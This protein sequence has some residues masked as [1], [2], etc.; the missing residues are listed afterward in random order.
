MPALLIGTEAACADRALTP[1]A[2]APAKLAISAVRDM[3]TS[4]RV[5]LQMGLATW[6]TF[7]TSSIELTLNAS[8][9]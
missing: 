4:F 8:V 2:I 5:M 7:Q 9:S 3:S 6:T 1:S